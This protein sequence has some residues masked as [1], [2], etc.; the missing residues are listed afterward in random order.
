[1][2]KD[3]TAE[4]SRILVEATDLALATAVNNV[5]HVRILNCIHDPARAN[6]VY[7]LTDKGSPKTEDF[8]HNPRVSFITIPPQGTAFVRCEDA[9]I[10]E[11]EYTIESLLELFRAQVYKFDFMYEHRR[12]RMQLFELRMHQAS[13]NL[14]MRRTI[15]VRFP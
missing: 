15:T 2:M 13:V 1:M 4:L 11:S 7:L 8:A 3:D 9:V 12:D 5:P 6:V 14:D 10:S